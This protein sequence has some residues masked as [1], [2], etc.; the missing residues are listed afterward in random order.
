MSLSLSWKKLFS[1]LMGVDLYHNDRESS[2]IKH[3]HHDGIMTGYIWECQP[4]LN[5]IIH[6]MQYATA[7]ARKNIKWRGQSFI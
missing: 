6:N 2:F 1:E 4:K 5:K 3:I 7:R